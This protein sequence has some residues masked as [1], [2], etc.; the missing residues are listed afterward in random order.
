TVGIAAAPA[1]VD[2]HVATVAPAELPERIEEHR[3]AILTFSIGLPVGSDQQADAPHPLGL[4]RA[5][6]E[7]PRS[8]SGREQ[9]DELAAGYHSI[10][11]SARRSDRGGT[12][13]PSVLAVLRLMTKEKRVGCSTGMSPGF[14]PFRTLSTSVVT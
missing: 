10:A 14:A 9:R 11:R 1:I 3:D 6:D 2:P 13:R 12:V 5:Y 4:L 8:R 7:R